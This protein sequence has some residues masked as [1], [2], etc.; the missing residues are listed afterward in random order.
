[1]E[2]ALN[3]LVL[4]LLLAAGPVLADCY[5]ADQD[6]GRLE[7]AGVADGA[8]FTGH[9]GEFSVRLC[10]EGDDLSSAQIEVQIQTGSADTGNRM[11]DGELHGKNLF[12]VAEFPQSTWTSGEIAASGEG[13]LA[14]GELALRDV[15][16]NQPVQLQFSGGDAPVLSGRA[17][18]L[19]L[20]WNVGLGPDFSDP[21]FVR[22]RVDLSFELKLRPE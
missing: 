1:M 22:N 6:S 14:Q 9:F 19:R 5:L 3:W 17:E 15:R 4:G 21:D 16:R 20:D 12:S 11:R 8:G 18:I 10:M 13:W 7:F 2:K